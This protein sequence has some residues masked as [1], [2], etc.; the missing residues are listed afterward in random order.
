MSDV[1]C[2]KCDEKCSGSY[3]VIDT[4]AYGDPVTY[5]VCKECYEYEIERDAWVNKMM[6][7]RK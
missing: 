7:L 2:C 6:E 5:V 4:D 3:S 1:E